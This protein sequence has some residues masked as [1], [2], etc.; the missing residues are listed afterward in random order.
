MAKPNGT[1]NG[2]ASP[3]RVIG[4]NS[5]THARIVRI[6]SLYKPRSM[7]WLLD[8]ITLHWEARWRS[9][10][11]PDQWKRYL[12]DDVSA[13]EARAIYAAAERDGGDAPPTAP[14]SSAKD[15]KEFIL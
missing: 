13:A 15:A 4:V 14:G 8:R 5:A 3:R 11:S 6:A 2:T 10:M 1:T 9:R 7:A 12:V